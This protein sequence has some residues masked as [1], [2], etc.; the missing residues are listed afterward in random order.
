MLFSFSMV[1]V[2][3]LFSFLLFVIVPQYND[4]N[5]NPYS[6]VF[7]LAALVQSVGELEFGQQV[8]K[9][10]VSWIFFYGH[11]P[12]CLAYWC[13]FFLIITLLICFP[14]LPPPMPSSIGWIFY[15]LL[16]SCWVVP[17]FIACYIS[18]L[19]ICLPN[20]Y[21]MFGCHKC[22]QLAEA[23]ISLRGTE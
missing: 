19:S 8:W 5:G 22:T 6:D 18:D 15:E 2:I 21:V 11:T 16:F 10:Y 1:H 9:Y 14:D 4:N 12:C 7:W 3:S 17:I 13:W 23:A 20:K